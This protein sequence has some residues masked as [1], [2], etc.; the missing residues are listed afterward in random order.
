[1]RIEPKLLTY[2]EAT[3][4]AAKAWEG[5]QELCDSS[6]PE[7]GALDGHIR[8]RTISAVEA[9][10]RAGGL[11]RQTE[12]PIEN[13]IQA[14]LLKVQGADDATFRQA[15]SELGLIAEDKATDEAGEAESDE[16]KKKLLLG[17]GSPVA[18]EGEPPA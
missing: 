3:V 2:D 5:F 9:Y 18:E 17:E 7:Y 16:V 15:L 10:S 6:A 14:A 13:C 4:I 8:D 11:L 1:M 12:S